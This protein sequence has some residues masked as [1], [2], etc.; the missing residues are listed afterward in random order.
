MC[1]GWIFFRTTP[2]QFLPI[3]QSIAALPGAVVSLL[4]DYSNYWQQAWFHFHAIL[5]TL[6]GTLK[7]FVYKNWTFAVYAWGLLLFMA[8]VWMTDYLGWRKHVEFADL[9]VGMPWPLRGVIILALVYAIVFFARREA[10]EFIY[11]A[12]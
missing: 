7:G 5:V 2:E 8:P 11:F 9:Y 1:I 3:I 4:H 10:N 12:F 6:V